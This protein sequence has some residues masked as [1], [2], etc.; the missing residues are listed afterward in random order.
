MKQIQYAAMAMAAMTLAA[1]ADTDIREY[2]VEKPQSIADYEYLSAYGNLK[3]YVDRTAHPIFNLGGAIEAGDY[4]KLGQVYR[5]TNA[6]FDQVTFGNAMKYA[7]CVGDNGTMDFTTVRTSVENVTNAGL[8][9]YG[10]T[11][12]WHAQQNVKWLNSL[13][14]DQEISGGEAA[15]VEDKVQNFAGM[16]KFPFYVMGYEP[17]VVDGNL[18]A[19]NPDGGW[20]QFF[21]ADGISTNPKYEYQVTIRMRASVPGEFNLQFGNWGE[22]LE[23]KGS[24]PEGGEWGD[25]TI[26]YEGL[27]TTN[28]FVVIQPGVYS[29]T[30]E[31]ESITIAHTESTGGKYIKSYVT[32]GDAEGDDVSCFFMAEGAGPVACR[33][34][35]AGTG[36]DGE[37]HAYE[38][39]CAAN[40]STD[41][42][43]QFFITTPGHTWEA[44]EEYVVKFKMRA[45]EERTADTQ[46]HNGP[47]NYMHWSFIGSPAFTTEWKEFKYS[48]VI[49]AEQAGCNTIAFNLSK[50]QTACTYWFDDIEWGV[51][52]SGNTRPLSDQEK[53]E[54]LTA[55]MERWI[56]GMMEA[57]EGRVEDWDLVNEAISG[58]GDN[59]YGFY[60]LQSDP[61]HENANDFYWQDY[62]GSI[63]YVRTAHKYA[64]Q[65]F[66]E[67]G[68]NPANLKLFIN[69]YNLESDWDNN[70]KLKSL[71]HWI[72]R[73]EEDGE[74][75]IDGIGTQMHISCYENE[76]TQESKKAH[77]EEMFRL[78]AATGK[79]VR[80]TELDMGYVDIDGNDLKY[81]ELTLEQE[82]RMADYYQFIVEKYFELIPAD[83]QYGITFWCQTDSPE[84][85]GWRPGAPVG[86]W[87]RSY[88][89]KPAYAG[90]AEGLMNN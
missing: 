28:S 74:T 44:G 80:V 12:G 18:V 87:Y 82:K 11:L 84:G 61:N 60:P 16:S 73:W 31:I 88:S 14:A 50:A 63:D 62:L 69:D 53:K 68:G 41:W 83:Q 42:D 56:S 37:G 45:S 55:E 71:I 90:V 64:R 2:A 65:Y 23:K 6:N 9:V 24:Y 59:G 67:Y 30:M 33:I 13:I 29:G 3:D 40:P 21:I 7:S 49:G 15:L 66:A 34:G 35:D 4:N 43:T 75:R 57:T 47:G 46:A 22:L 58:G 81:D 52:V 77:I 86:L 54:I 19:S 89:R 1:C 26:K 79:L 72:G 20:Y 25:V 51:E 27:T 76:A 5:V 36:A 10:H 70:K 39:H 85:S 32:N 48:G 78:M 38:V 8:K 17:D